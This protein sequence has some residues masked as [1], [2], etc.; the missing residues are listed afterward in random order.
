MT[1]R[2]HRGRGRGDVPGLR[3]PGRRPLKTLL[4]IVGDGEQ[5]EPN[6]FRG[7]REEPAVREGFA[8]QVHG[9]A[10]GDPVSTVKSA[11]KE[12]E[13]D[14]LS[15]Y[16][17]DAV[18]CVLDVEAEGENPLLPRARRLAAEHGIQVI[19]SNPAFE[20]WLL[21]HFERTASPFQHAGAA[22][23]RLNKHWRVQFSQSYEK[24]DE[25]LYPRLAG[26][27]RTAIDNAKWVRAVH[28]A[29]RQ[30]TAECNSATEVYGLVEYLRPVGQ[31]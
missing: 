25:A 21:A 24:A 6:Y 14:R 20:V 22:I 23:R 15:G 17:F 2:P 12:I 27:T 5:S 30:D 18:Y 7:L 3:R 31:S 13:R 16:E 4:L 9:A 26:R 11:I 1:R 29:G 28:F 19:L 8:I 10:A